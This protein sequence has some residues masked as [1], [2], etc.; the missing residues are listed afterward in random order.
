MIAV[1]QFVY[2]TRFKGLTTACQ[3]HSGCLV[4]AVQEHNA[5]NVIGGNMTVQE[6]RTN[7]SQIHRL[8][9]GLGGSPRKAEFDIST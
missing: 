8:G 6:G 3:T 7:T 1:L 9:V 4:T 2:S 5:W